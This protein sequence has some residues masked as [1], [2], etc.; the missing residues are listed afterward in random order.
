M[1]GSEKN[2]SRR[3]EMS[4]S[5]RSTRR[6]FLKM[7]GIAPITAM[8]FERAEMRRKPSEKSFAARP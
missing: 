7:I 1:K 3:S 8:V 4:P 2:K 5:Y 6:D